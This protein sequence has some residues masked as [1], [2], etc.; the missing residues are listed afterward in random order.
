MKYNGAHKEVEVPG[1]PRQGS[2][3]EIAP[4]DRPGI[5]WFI[6]GKE[7]EWGPEEG[8]ETGRQKQSHKVRQGGWGSKKYRKKDIE[9]SGNTWQ[10]REKR[11]WE[12][13]EV[14]KNPFY[15]TTCAPPHLAAGDDVTP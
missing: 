11:E 4:W 5:G 14:A 9:A 1:E 2:S 6:W 15:K 7:G 12:R 3:W 10:L 13:A 8:I